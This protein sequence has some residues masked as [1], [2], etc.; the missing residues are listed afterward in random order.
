MIEL[1]SATSSSSFSSMSLV[2][3]SSRSI[4]SNTNS[5]SNSNVVLQ[6][7]LHKFSCQEIERLKQKYRVQHTSC[8]THLQTLLNRNR[9]WKLFS[10]SSFVVIMTN[11]I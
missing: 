7:H 11:R 8:F 3:S 6:A 4:C 10:I 5:S 2:S 9:V 1:S